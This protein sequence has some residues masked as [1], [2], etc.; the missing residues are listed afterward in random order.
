MHGKESDPSPINLNRKVR[1]EPDHSRIRG[2]MGSLEWK[3]ETTRRVG[4]GNYGSAPSRVCGDWHHV[5][6]ENAA[7]DVGFENVAARVDGVSVTKN[8]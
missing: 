6:H 2:K 7:T 8:W 5:N 4:D 1:A 3:A